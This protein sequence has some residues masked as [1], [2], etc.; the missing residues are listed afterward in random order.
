MGGWAI[1]FIKRLRLE[2]LR[3]LHCF[4]PSPPRGCFRLPLWGCSLLFRSLRG[5]C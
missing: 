3:G 4:S 2:D 5:G 1:L